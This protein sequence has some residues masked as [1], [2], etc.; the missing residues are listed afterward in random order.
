MTRVFPSHDQTRLRQLLADAA[1]FNLLA[2]AFTYP[3]PGHHAIVHKA[4][5]RVCAAR[6]RRGAVGRAL[7][8]AERAWRD[9]DSGELPAEYIRLFL[10][11]GPCPLHET[12]YGD[13]R[14]I[15]GRPVELADLQGFYQAFG[16]AQSERNPDLPDHLCAE[17]EFYSLLLIKQAYALNADWTA[18]QDVARRAVTAFLNDHLGRW[19]PTLGQE[20]AEHGAAEPYRALAAMLAA[21]VAEQCRRHRVAPHLAGGRLP[22]DFMQ[23][24]ALVCPRAAGPAPSR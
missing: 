16:F 18:R 24:D 13:G 11:S 10:G 1:L 21:A 17:L 7:A 14:R 15:A 23:D 22:H 4:F 6:G 20:L 5:D 9:A 8:A 19:V 2:R 12:A 3:R